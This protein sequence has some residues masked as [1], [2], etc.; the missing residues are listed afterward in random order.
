MRCVL[1]IGS[2]LAEP[3]DEVW[4]YEGTSRTGS[5]RVHSLT[6]GATQVP[7]Q[8]ICSQSSALR[9]GMARSRWTSTA[10]TGY[11]LLR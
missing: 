4:W 1:F 11:N 5:L 6:T 8:V 2:T 7:W 3:H 10:C 9:C